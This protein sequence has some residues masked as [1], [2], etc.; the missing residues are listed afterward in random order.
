MLL[1][2]LLK[3]LSDGKVGIVYHTKAEITRKEKNEEAFH[4]ICEIF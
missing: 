2:K 4:I 3:Y 1:I